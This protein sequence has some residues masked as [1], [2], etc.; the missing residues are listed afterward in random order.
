[1]NSIIIDILKVHDDVHII[2][3][4]ELVTNATY[5]QP[6]EIFYQFRNSIFGS[7]LLAATN[8]GFCYLSFVVHY[9]TALND[10]HQEF[11]TST[12]VYAN[13]HCFDQAIAI[14][15]GQVNDIIFLNL[16]LMGSSFELKVWQALFQVKYG[17]SISYGE[18][19]RCVGQPKGAR[20]V[21]R[22]VGNNNI[23]LLVP[24]HRVVASGGKIGGY[25]YGIERKIEILNHEQTIP[26]PFSVVYY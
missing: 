7:L 6:R 10:L 9:E 21:A 2:L 8:Q 25:K 14:I 13:N 20:A 17:E 11:P 12:L 23:M 3:T 18:L 19:A 26:L 5:L 24:C 22:A 16:H 4:Y 15:S 1:M